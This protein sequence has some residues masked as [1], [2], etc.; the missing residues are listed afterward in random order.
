MHGN[1][2]CRVESVDIAPFVLGANMTLFSFDFAGCGKSEG[3]F[4]SLGWH[5]RDDVNG[6]LRY[7]HGIRK[8][9]GYSHR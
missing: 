7:V 9:D 2:S 5:E 1:S 3:E 6:I 4:I 8:P